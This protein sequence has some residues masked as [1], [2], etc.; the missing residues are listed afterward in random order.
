MKKF[1]VLLLIAVL[2]IVGLC[3]C[4][5][6]KP[7]EE[8]KAGFKVGYGREDITPTESVLLAGYGN[9]SRRMSATELRRPADAIFATAI[10]F[11]DI[12]GNSVILVQTD[13]FHSFKHVSDE[14]R[15]LIS[16]QT[17]LPR[18]NIMI[19]GTH[20]HSAPDLDN[21]EQESIGRY[22]TFL[23]D[24]IVKA[25]KAAMDDR[26]IAEMYV[27]SI[28]AKNMNFVR[29]YNLDEGGVLG[30]NFGSLLPG[31][32][33]GH[34]HDVDN[35]MQVVRFSRDGGKD[36]VM[37]NWQSQLL[38]SVTTSNSKYVSA[39]LA[40]VVRDV[41]EDSM[42]CLT[43]Y[44]SGAS[45]NVNPSS[46][47]TSENQT[48]NYVDQGCYLAD[49]V[50]TAAREAEKVETGKLQLLAK[51]YEGQ[52]NHTEDHLV[53]QAKLIAAHWKQTSNNA[54]CTQ[55]GAPYGINSPY[56]AEAIVEKKDMPQ[57]MDVEMYAFAIGDL[58]FIAA[59][60]DMFDENG[61]YIKENS[62]YK[63]TFITTYCNDHVGF[64]AS[65]EGFESDS[66]EA[67]IGYFVKGTAETLAQ[68]YVGM[69]NQ[70][71]AAK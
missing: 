60:Y 32:I 16:Q 20:T 71:H 14:A 55:M 22:K 51:N 48:A 61:A 29:H 3:A 4:Q 21:D 30:D 17:G 66:F 39:D 41:V 62:P 50:T 70:L 11:T 69:L 42:N 35:Q 47:I 49:Y 43:M 2:L 31:K 27:G 67:N 40:G 46:R 37:I 33:T 18:E 1:L 38:R 54:E 65:E 26:K 36:V 9:T 13:L 44:V 23:V 59:P 12:E 7:A 25:A 63:M 34:T 45:G 52:V 8:P 64:I 24:K 57:T 15:D 10:A 53:E 19:A 68:E 6:P 56:H 28:N 5:D 58:A